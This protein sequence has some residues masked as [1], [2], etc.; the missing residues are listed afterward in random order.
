MRENGFYW[1]NLDGK[2]I[3]AEYE[4]GLFWTIGCQ[5]SWK[6]DEFDA[7]GDK[8]EIPEKYSVVQ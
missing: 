2:W 8:I 4:E 5:F 3:I 6:Q 1:V 7:I